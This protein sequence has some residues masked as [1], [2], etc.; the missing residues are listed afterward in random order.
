MIPRIPIPRAAGR[1]LGPALTAAC[2]LGTSSRLP[3]QAPSAPPDSGATL[4]FQ[5]APLQVVV[6]S[7]A[8]MAGL[9]V[10][11]TGLPSK[12]VTLRSPTPVPRRELRSML[13]S[14]LRSNGLALVQ[15][16]GLARIVGTGPEASAAPPPGSPPPQGRAAGAELQDEGVRLY[17][18][19]LRHSSADKVAQTLREVFGLGG[20]PG[21]AGGPA[22][23][24]RRERVPNPLTAEPAAS[25]AVGGGGSPGQ[26][27]GLSA[28]LRG[29]V[30]VVPDLLTN[31]LMIRGEAAD[32][33][34]ILAAVQAIDV[35]PLQVLIEVLIAE[36]GRSNSLDLG[37]RATARGESSADSAV[38]GDGGLNLR[39]K[40]TIGSAG[41]LALRVL[42]VGTIRADVVL[43]ALAT[44]SN[45]SILSRPIVLAQN[46]QE[47]R[48]LVGDQRP[49]VQISRALPT[50]G[51]VRDQVIQYRDVGTQLNIT[52]TINPDGYV[53]LEV[54][55]EVSAASE[56]TQFG[57]PVIRTREVETKLFVKDGH[58]AVIGGLVDRQQD[59]V[60]SGIPVLRSIPLLGHLFRSTRRNTG[61]TELFI[62]LTPHVIRNDEEMER[63]SDELKTN[64]RM[65]GERI[66]DLPPLIESAPSVLRK[67][68]P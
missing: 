26:G 27:T 10:S 6:A 54:R 68:E 17:V 58:T 7:L 8:E 53:T 48:I 63:M 18:H 28:Q 46:N 47:A 30:Q 33:R 13:E 22:R 4:N 65:V 12:T 23:D 43:D 44:T 50:D 35:R 56:E 2:L 31:S 15:E 14:V 38:L 62:L 11:Y 24:V 19:R 29:P 39:G 5:D 21:D 64:T 60:N 57:A 3:A 59:A 67:R 1:L 16:G 61:V 9:T 52:P 49:F 45:V 40:L 42:G 55:Q 25:P 34:T 41:D 51:A 37:V 32:Y 66:D 36:V 20:R